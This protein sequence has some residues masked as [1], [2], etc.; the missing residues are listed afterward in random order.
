MSLIALPQLDGTPESAVARLQ[1]YAGYFRQ[2][3]VEVA[4][5]EI[6]SALEEAANILP[7]LASA[8]ECDNETCSKVG[9]VEYFADEIR[10]AE[11]SRVELEALIEEGAA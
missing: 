3:A 10:K 1:A 2:S 9:D 7:G 11:Q 5:Y 4:L 6:A 8:E